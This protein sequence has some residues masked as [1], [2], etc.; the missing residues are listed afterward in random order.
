MKNDLEIIEKLIDDTISDRLGWKKKGDE[1]EVTFFVNSN[2]KKI[3]N[4]ELIFRMY[5]LDNAVNTIILSMCMFKNGTEY[6]IKNINDY[7][8]KLTELLACVIYSYKEKK[9]R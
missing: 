1:Y 3:K 9:N 7:Q 2:T 4:T 8:L 6:P 5:S